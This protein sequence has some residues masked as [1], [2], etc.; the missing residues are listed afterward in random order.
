MTL[1][2]LMMLPGLLCNE[3]TWAAQV[4]AL[5]RLQCVVPSY[6]RLDSIGAMARSVLVAAPS[7]RFAL[8]GHSMGGRVALE[9]MRLAPHR[10]ERIALLDTGVGG[11]R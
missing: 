7:E 9:V 8:A 5:P 3:I 4:A 2:V 6:G 11:S 10:G 1:P